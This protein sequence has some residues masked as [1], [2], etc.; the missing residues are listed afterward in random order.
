MAFSLA[1]R[2]L[3]SVLLRS[4]CRTDPTAWCFIPF[5]TTQIT[6]CSQAFLKLWQ[7]PGPCPDGP[8]QSIDLQSGLL[9]MALANFGLSHE[10]L[11]DVACGR[12]QTPEPTLQLLRND[13]LKVQITWSPVLTDEGL[14]S[15]RL[16]QFASDMDHPFHARVLEQLLE[17][18]NQLNILSEREQQVVDLLFAGLTNKA[19]ARQ[20]QISEKTVEKHRARIMQKLRVSSTAE[21]VRLVAQARLMD[22]NRLP[23]AA[24][25]GS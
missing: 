1:D 14:P 12:M 17:A 4:L 8:R 20:T 2:Q 16:L 6:W 22:D 21:L 19:I 10:V 18:R 7:L 24:P 3:E 5:G 13:G 9:Q 25:L 11:V 15:G 23:D